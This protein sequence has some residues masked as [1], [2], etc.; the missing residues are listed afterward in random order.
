M[1]MRTPTQGRY[2]WDPLHTQSFKARGAGVGCYLGK[3]ALTE[4]LNQ[5]QKVP[6]DG[7]CGLTA[8]FTASQEVLGGGTEEHTSMNSSEHTLE[9]HG[10]KIPV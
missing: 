1:A 6:T 8:S 9:N 2:G 4:I 5:S 10:S 7:A 3:E